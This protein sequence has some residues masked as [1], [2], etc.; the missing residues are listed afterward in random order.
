M[1]PSEKVE[2]AACRKCSLFSFFCTLLPSCK[3]YVCPCPLVC[4]INGSLIVHNLIYEEL[5]F[6]GINTGTRHGR[7]SEQ[8]MVWETMHDRAQ[9]FATMDFFPHN[10]RQK[11]QELV[12]WFA[13]GDRTTISIQ[14]FM[15][16]FH[17]VSAPV[18]PNTCSLTTLYSLCLRLN[19]WPN[20]FS[21]RWR[22]FAPPRPHP[23]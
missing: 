11:V 2:D 10:E 12:S 18:L 8:A 3:R 13:E 22:L 17:N 7:I 6:T 14:P 1:I 16:C 23:P 20:D 15:D 9:L 4:R 19:T 21:L 5:S